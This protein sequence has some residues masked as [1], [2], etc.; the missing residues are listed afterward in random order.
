[1]TKAI[2]FTHLA[3]LDAHDQQSIVR[4]FGP[5]INALANCKNVSIA[6][7]YIDWAIRQTVKEQ[8]AK[9]GRVDLSAG[10][11]IKGTLFDQEMTLKGRITELIENYRTIHSPQFVLV[12]TAELNTVFVKLHEVA[13]DLVGYLWGA[14][15]RFTYDVP[16]FAEAVLIL[17][18]GQTPHLA[19]NPVVRFDED[20]LPNE[21]SIAALIK[22]FEIRS[23]KRVFFFFSGHYG[24]KDALSYDP[25]SDQAVRTHWFTPDLA[26]DG[27]D[28]YGDKVDTDKRL[29]ALIHCRTFLADISQLGAP[30]VCSVEKNGELTSTVTPLASKAGWGLASAGLKADIRPPE[31]DQN[32]QQVISGAGLIMS[33]RAVALLPPFTVFKENAIWVDDYVKRLLHEALGDITPVDPADSMSIQE[34]VFRQRRHPYQQGGDSL[35][36]QKTYD[37][38]T[39]L[40]RGCML[41]RVVAANSA[42]PTQLTAFA[43]AV[44]A[45]AI[46]CPNSAQTNALDKQQVKNDAEERGALVLKAFQSNDYTGTLLKDWADEKARDPSFVSTIAQEICEDCCRYLEFLEVWPT[47]VRAVDRVSMISAGW[48]FKS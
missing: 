36:I 11:P 6:F 1:M 32:Y 41:C 22:S 13:P 18:R 20:V 14:G 47:F 33:R 26:Q 3:G 23:K 7:L 8:E 25:V 34:A 2:V 37:Y 40:L 17:S 43:K 42:A 19:A 9:A 45:R 16:K 4:K 27:A 28:R 35:S 10:F 46:L 48:L 44:K 30:Q 21:E 29:R 12:G 31:T 39:R 38:F 15:G 24:S 5:L